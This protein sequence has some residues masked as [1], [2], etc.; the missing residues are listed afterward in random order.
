MVN[1]QAY[2]TVNA[3]IQLSNGR[4]IVNE[5]TRSINPS[6]ITVNAVHILIDG[7]ADVVAGSALAGIDC[8]TPGTA[9]GDDFATGAGWI[10]TPSSAKGNFGGAGG[11]KNSGAIWGHLI[12]ADKSANGVDV[13]GAVTGYAVLGSTQ[14]QIEGSAKINGVSGF[15][16]RVVLVENGEPGRGDWFSIS[17]SNGYTA[18]GNLGG[19]N[20]QLH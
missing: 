2:P 10:T 9:A 8:N 15:S 13:E 1:G 7:L 12:Y 17:L 20:I 14:R 4:I 5:Q 19:G 11:M 6:A 3:P 16:F 18:S